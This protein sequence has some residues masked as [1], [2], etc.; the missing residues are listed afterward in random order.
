MGRWRR[1]HP[2]TPA[3]SPRHAQWR[4]GTFFG[5]NPSRVSA[6]DMVAVLMATPGRRP[7][8]HSARPTWRRGA[9]GP[10]RAAPLRRQHRSAAAALVAPSGPP[11]PS[12]AGAAASGDRRS[13]PPK[14]GRPP[15]VQPGVQGPQQAVA[16][17][18]GYCFIRAGIATPHHSGATRS[19]CRARVDDPVTRRNQES[20]LVGPR[21]RGQSRDD[22]RCAATAP[23]SNTMSIAAQRRQGPNDRELAPLLHWNLFP[24][25]RTGKTG[26]D[27]CTERSCGGGVNVI[28]PPHPMARPTSTYSW[29]R[30][31]RLPREKWF[32]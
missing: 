16:K 17:S 21:I 20:P 25:S 19:N 30:A 22:P 5:G 31:T 27:W 28:V 4:S 1:A 29:G 23:P 8:E 15:L 12:P 10:A 14:C 18:A 26:K 2:A 7:S 13:V 11:S 24:V 32:R 9:P 6:R 3:A